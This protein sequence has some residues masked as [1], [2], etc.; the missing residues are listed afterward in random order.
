MKRER[1]FPSTLL[2]EAYTFLGFFLGFLILQ[3]LHTKHLPDW[4]T[5]A[6]SAGGILSGIGV[7]DLCLYLWKRL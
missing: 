6:V 2:A 1:G 4:S 7:V 3:Y 5:V